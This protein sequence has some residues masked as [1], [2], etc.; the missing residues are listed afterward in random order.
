MDTNFIPKLLELADKYKAAQD[1]KVE[2]EDGA[3][4]LCCDKGCFRFFYDFNKSF[5]DDCYENVPMFHWQ[6]QPK[7]IQLRGLIDRRMVEPAL[8]M[9]I[10]HMVSH[11]SFT[12]TLKDIAVFETNL[13]EFITRSEIDHVFADFSGD[14]Y[15]NCIMSTKNNL[16]ASMELGF[17]PDGSE[18]VLLHEV[19]ARTGI[20]SDLPVDTQTVQYPIYVFKGEKTEKYNEIDFELYGMNNTEADCIRFILWALTDAE[21][22]RQLRRDYAHIE[23]VWAAAEKASATLSNTEVEG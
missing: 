6:A 17:L 5:A 19:V 7:Y 11:D 23:K 15:T 13:F 4:K 21:R 8:A 1:L 22:I 18:P 14:V 2:L 9:R 20:A 10:H 12:R 16:K 3:V